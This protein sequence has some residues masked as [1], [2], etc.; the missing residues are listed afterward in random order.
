[1]WIIS[2][3]IAVDLKDPYNLIGCSHNINIQ[4][5]VQEYDLLHR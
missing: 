3:S 4:L 2:P 1:M 5:I